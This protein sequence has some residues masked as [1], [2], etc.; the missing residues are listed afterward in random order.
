MTKKKI[1]AFSVIVIA[2]LII[3]A[4]VAIVTGLLYLLFPLIILIATIIVGWLIKSFI[5]WLIVNLDYKK[6]KEN[7]ISGTKKVVNKIKIDEGINIVK[8]SIDELR[9]KK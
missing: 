2:L 8:N 6:I 1:K 5:E 4:I 3:L 9:G 7:T